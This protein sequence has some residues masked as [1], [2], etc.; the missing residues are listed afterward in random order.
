MGH[1]AGDSEDRQEQRDCD[2]TNNDAHYD[3][4][5]GFYEGGCGFDGVLEFLFIEDRDFV[6]DL[7]KLAA[8]FAG[9]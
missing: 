2:S 1:D 5:Q 7:S 6:A 4:H 8:L 3:N 9:L